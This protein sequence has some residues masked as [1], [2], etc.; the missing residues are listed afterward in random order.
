MEVLNLNITKAFFDTMDSTIETWKE[1]MRNA[2][3]KDME[4]VCKYTAFF[5]SVI[6][7]THAIES[8]QA[9]KTAEKRKGFS[10][11]FL[12]NMSEQPIRWWFPTVRTT[13]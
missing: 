2:T 13:L 9:K 3:V 4:V 10:P 6:R 12:S 5:M 11:L 8:F 1:D 7:L